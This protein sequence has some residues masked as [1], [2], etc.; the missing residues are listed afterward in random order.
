MTAVTRTARTLLSAL[1]ALSLFLG[2][3]FSALSLILLVGTMVI[4]VRSY[5]VYDR[6]MMEAQPDGRLL[7]V[8]RGGLVGVSLRAIP[9][10]REPTTYRP[11]ERPRVTYDADPL[12]SSLMA[13]WLGPSSGFWRRIGFGYE[14]RESF[15]G[16]SGLMRVTAWRV[17][18]W[19]IALVTAAGPVYWARVRMKGWRRFKEGAC[20]RC[21][22]DLRATPDRCPECGTVPAR[23][24]SAKGRST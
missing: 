17:P 15:V 14:S 10:P 22:Y 5:R 23:A 13:E 1:S 20:V 11:V 2:Y 7:S 9:T 12:G 16:H 21:G 24:E 4:W 8:E 3:A 19:A 18:F 6:L